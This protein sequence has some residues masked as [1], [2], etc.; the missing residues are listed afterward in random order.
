MFCAFL[1]ISIPDVKKKEKKKE[2][3]WLMFRQRLDMCLC[4]SAT[5]Y[6]ALVVFKCKFCSCGIQR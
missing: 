5:D 3:L 2:A 1:L 6:T 4:S